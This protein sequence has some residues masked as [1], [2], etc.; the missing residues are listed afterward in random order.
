[1]DFK[2]L[3]L[4]A[5]F[6]FQRA[7]GE[8]SPEKTFPHQGTKIPSADSHQPSASETR[9]QQNPK[10]PKPQNPLRK[11]G[12]RRK[13]IYICNQGLIIIADP[14]IPSSVVKSKVLLSEST[15]GV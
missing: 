13:E 12:R 1:M 15:V 7:P 3:Q 8:I 10:T 5:H 2:G 9:R 4:I 14:T 6:N 11:R